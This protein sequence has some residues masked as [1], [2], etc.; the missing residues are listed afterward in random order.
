VSHVSELDSELSTTHELVRD[1]ERVSAVTVGRFARVDLVVAAVSL[2]GVTIAN[3]VAVQS[4]LLWI[5]PAVLAALVAALLVAIGQADRG[6]TIPAVAWMGL[7]VGGSEL[8]AEAFRNAATVQRVTDG[9]VPEAVILSGLAGIAW[10]AASVLLLFTLVSRVYRVHRGRRNWDEGK[11]EGTPVLLSDDVG[12]AV[13]GFLRSSIVVP[14][15]ITE[16]EASVARL[17][18]A[19]EREHLRG[20]DPL[21]LF[22]GLLLVTLMPWNLGLWWMLQ[23]LRLAVEVD[24]DDRVLGQGEWDVRTYGTVLLQIGERR[25]RP[26]YSLAG[27]SFP[28]SSLEERILAM[29]GKGKRSGAALSILLTLVVT[30]LLVGALS[31]PSPTTVQEWTASG[32]WCDTDSEGAEKVQQEFLGRQ[33]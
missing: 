19:H 5:V 26:G 21:L 11:I 15:W 12:P 1:P 10:V 24:C 29:T 2:I 20:R 14:R 7:G 28:R 18:I 33:V 32:Y 13:V 30:G 27:F 31:I 16:T 9:S 17:I 8:T 25:S 4:A 22:G 23:R 6:S 3:T